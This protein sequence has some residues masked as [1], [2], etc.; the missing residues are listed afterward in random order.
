MALQ[1]EN[2]GLL[3]RQVIGCLNR[4]RCLGRTLFHPPQ[5]L[6]KMLGGL[7]FITHYLFLP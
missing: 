2:N 7:I 5:A 6:K 3:L 4:L 1:T